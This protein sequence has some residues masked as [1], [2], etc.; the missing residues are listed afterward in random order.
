MPT[1]K[2]PRK[3]VSVP[4]KKAVAKKVA[5]KIDADKIAK[6]KAAAAAKKN[7]A[8]PKQTAAT[9]TAAAVKKAAVA[10]RAPK[11]ALSNDNGA[12]KRKAQPA[13]AKS[14]ITKR[15]YKPGDTL[16][17]EDVIYKRS[18]IKD[19]SRDKKELAAALIHAPKSL[20][21]KMTD[22]ELDELLYGNHP[23]WDGVD[24]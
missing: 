20:Y 13:P 1:L 23:Y 8:A 16:P 21:A 5:P 19:W 14:Q 24:A 10:K 12:T 18:E 7:G 11:P 22:A 15:T 3:T 6:A 2:A 9:K 17:V 4:A